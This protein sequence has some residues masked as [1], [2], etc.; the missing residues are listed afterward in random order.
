MSVEL[1]SDAV[2]HRIDATRDKMPVAQKHRCKH[3]TIFCDKTCTSANHFTRLA[4]GR[5]IGATSLAK[6][7]LS[8][9]RRKSNQLVVLKT[10]RYLVLF[11]EAAA[12]QMLLYLHWPHWLDAVH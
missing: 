8:K 6:K 3:L 12:P 4:S 11:S 9:E 5:R 10:S 2:G 7:R 1:L